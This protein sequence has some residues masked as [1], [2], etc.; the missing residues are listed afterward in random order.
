MDAKEIIKETC[1]LLKSFGVKWDTPIRNNALLDFGRKIE[2]KSKE[3]AEERCDKAIMYF[4]GKEYNS[5]T[6]MKG[7]HIASGKEEEG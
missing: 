3:E 7:L 2:A 4:N 6:I 1:K 5:T